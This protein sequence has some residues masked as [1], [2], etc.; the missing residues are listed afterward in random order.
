MN[1]YNDDKETFY[2]N[3]ERILK[4]IDPFNNQQ[5]TFSECV[6]YFA[7][8]FY[9]I[10]DNKGNYIRINVLDKISSDESILDKNDSENI[11]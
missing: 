7:Q 5:I 3:V 4:E 2:I 9:D 10:K 6:S 11:Y 1:I 8:E